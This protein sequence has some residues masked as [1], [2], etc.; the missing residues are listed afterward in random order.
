MLYAHPSTSSCFYH[1]CR[2]V[3]NGQLRC[4]GLR[5][6]CITTHATLSPAYLLDSAGPLPPPS[7]CHSAPWLKILSPS[8]SSQGLCMG[9]EISAQASGQVSRT[10]NIPDIESLPIAFPF[11]CHGLGRTLPP[12]ALPL[13]N[14]RPVLT[15]RSEAGIW[16]RGPQPGGRLHA[17][18]SAFL[19]PMVADL[20]S[21]FC[22]PWLS[23]RPAVAW[24]V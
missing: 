1:T 7:F 17:V 20:V 15:T 8:P 12:C 4:D 10:L 3:I 23:V 22:A 11:V 16:W 18:M 24:H 13:A 19:A 2:K 6:T 14:H 9:P 5:S 21:L